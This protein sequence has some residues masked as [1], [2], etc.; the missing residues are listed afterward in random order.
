MFRTPQVNVYAADVERTVAFYRMLGFAET[1][2]TPAE[3]A[4]VHVE[5]RLDGFTLGVASAASAAADHGLPVAS[6]PGRGMEVAVWCD[7]VDDA[8]ALLTRAGGTV[9]SAPKPW[10]G[11]LRVAWVA[12]LDGNPVELVQRVAS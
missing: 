8:V 2:R 11:T 5:L 3:G 7:D 1:F 12:D 9:L 4:P 6:G 10:L